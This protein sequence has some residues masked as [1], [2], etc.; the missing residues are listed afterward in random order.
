MEIINSKQI[1][2][3][4]ANSLKEY[5]STLDKKPK[6]TIIQVEGDKASDSYIKNKVKLGNEIGIEVQHILLPNNVSQEELENTVDEMN[7]DSSV[8]GII[9]QLPLPSHIDEVKAINKINSFKDVDGLTMMQTGMLSFGD[10]NVLAPCTALGVTLILQEITDI[11]GKNV[12]IVNRSHLIG[13]PLQTILTRKNA[14]VTV[15]HSR[16]KDLQ[17]KMK[18]ADI[19]VTGIGKGKYF[20]SKYFRDGQIII[21]CSMNFVDGKLCGD[22]NVESVKDLDVKI[23]SGPGHTGPMTVLSLM[24]N[25]IKSYD[26]KK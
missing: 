17:W 8:N 11:E 6:L 23:A 16:T 26:L 15:C 3:N 7:N 10:K 18:E 19:V 9:V 25:T 21:D 1:K 14:T 4:E 22:V 2:E 12:V 24:K 13:M 5:V 20:D